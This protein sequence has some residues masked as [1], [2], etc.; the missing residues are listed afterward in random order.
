MPRFLSP[1]DACVRVK[2][3]T[4][5]KDATYSGRIIEV[6]DPGHARMLKSVGYVQAAAA[7]VPMRTGGY[8]CIDCDFASFF[9]LCSRCGAVCERPDLVA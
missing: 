6:N 1:D 7:G 3:P 9:R 8:R 4:G 2:V 5:S